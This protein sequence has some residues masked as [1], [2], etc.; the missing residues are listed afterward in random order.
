MNTKHIAFMKWL[1]DMQ[2]VKRD[3]YGMPIMSTCAA[4]YERLMEIY[5]EL[6]N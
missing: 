4:P 6:H 5:E 3:N 1:L 2:L